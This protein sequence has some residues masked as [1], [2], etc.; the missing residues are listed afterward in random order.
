MYYWD[1]QSWKST[2]SPDGRFRWDGSAW[3]PISSMAV[4]PYGVAVPPQR[5][6]TSWT[7]PLQL[8]VGGWYVWSI[9]YVLS[10]PIWLGGM[11]GQILNQSLQ[12]SQ[13]ANPEVSPPPPG[14]ADM[15]SGVMNVSL[16]ASVMFYAAIFVVILIGTWKRWTW[17]YYV[18]LA[19]L[20]LTALLTPF[21][22]VYVFI[23]GSLTRI[24]GFGLPSWIYLL[25]FVTGIPAVALFVWMLVAAVKRGPWAMRRPQMY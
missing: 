25:N 16:W 6:P 12:R 11:M 23:G 9:L 10:E 2:L 13:Q 24:N 5:Q 4:T 20:G 8:A 7:R 21:Q 1:G 22:L 18:V 14:F 19:L 17:M 3:T 15:M